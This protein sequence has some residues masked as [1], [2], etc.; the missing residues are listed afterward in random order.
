MNP[1]P[2][3]PELISRESGNENNVGTPGIQEREIPGKK[4]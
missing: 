2:G 3:N 1:I 4:H